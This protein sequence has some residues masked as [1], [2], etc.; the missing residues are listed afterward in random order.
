MFTSEW[1]RQTLKEPK[2]LPQIDRC[3]T[4]FQTNQMSKAINKHSQQTLVMNKQ[5]DRF[6]DLMTSNLSF[7][8]QVI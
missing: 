4:G 7:G 1:S 3:I 5:S 8:R 2:L 6:S